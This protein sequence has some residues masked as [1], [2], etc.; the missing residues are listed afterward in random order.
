MFFLY[1]LK[2]F[3]HTSHSILTSKSVE[4]IKGYFIRQL[5][6]GETN[7][8]CLGSYNENHHPMTLARGCSKGVG[9]EFKAPPGALTNHYLH[10][11]GC[12]NPLHTDDANCV[13]FCSFPGGLTAA[14]KEP[15]ESAPRQKTQDARDTTSLACAPAYFIGGALRWGAFQP[16]GMNWRKRSTLSLLWQ[17]LRRCRGPTAAW[18]TLLQKTPSARDIMQHGCSQ[19]FLKL[20]GM[21]WTT[22]QQQKHPL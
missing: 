20:S 10:Q 3:V 17:R 8:V 13:H 5:S 2:L 16:P 7:L 15:N 4:Q 9:A 6:F 11:G 1:S 21:T 19:H 22:R 18:Y 14:S 12:V